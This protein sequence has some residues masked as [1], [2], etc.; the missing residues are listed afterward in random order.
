MA[1]L[2]QKGRS[3]WQEEFMKVYYQGKEVGLHR[4][5]KRVIDMFGDSIRISPKHVIACKANNEVKDLNYIIKEGDTIELLDVTNKDGFRVYLRGALYIMSMAFKQLYP[6]AK[7]IINYQLSG[8]TF[9]NCDNLKITDD[10]IKNLKNRIKEIVSKDLEIEKVNMTKKE[11]EEFFK[12][13]NDEDDRGKLQIYNQNKDVVTL[14]FCEGY[15]NYFFG[16]MPLRTGYIDLIDV[17]KHGN[18]FIVRYPDSNKPTHLEKFRES[19]KLLSTLQEYEDIHRLMKIRTVQELNSFVEKGNGKD[20]ILTAEALQEKKMA[21]IADKISRHKKIK[22]VLIAGP[23]SSSKTTFAKRLCMQLRVNGL[24]PVTIGTDDYF[25]ERKDNPIDEN[26]EYDFETIDSIDLK[27]FNSHL[28]KLI[29]GEKV[30]IPRFDFKVGTKRYEENRFL[31]LEEDDVLVIEGIHCLNDK[32]TSKIPKEKKYKIYVSDLT[33]LNFDYYNR[34]SASDT[35]LIRRI[36]RDYNYRGY[37]ALE[38]IQRWSSVSR[39]ERKNIFPFQEEADVMFNTS[40]VYELAILA[41]HAVPLLKEIDNT[42]KEYAEAKRIVSLL[43]YFKEMDEYAIPNNSLLREFI[44]GSVF[45]Y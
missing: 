23:S 30:E 2:C 20:V 19:K 43:E 8:G 32:L 16:A 9:C 39:G 6:N 4:D 18:G 5:V 36:V 38:T 10:V 44:G 40:L 45:D 11:A 31:Q 42:H 26:G 21:E 29:N 22:M 27:L 17:N 24:K 1:G 33:V 15:Y 25:V 41:K 7:L 37:S 14:Y 28:T 34:I 3:K 13:E 35:R 12:K